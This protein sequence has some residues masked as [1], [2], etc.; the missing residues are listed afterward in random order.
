MQVAEESS[1]RVESSRVESDLVHET[2]L[3]NSDHEQDQPVH[4][5]V[6]SIYPYK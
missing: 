4:L 2:R 5:L 1:S 6:L 3:M